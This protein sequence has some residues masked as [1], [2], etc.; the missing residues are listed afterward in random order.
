MG[1]GESDSLARFDGRYAEA[2]LLAPDPVRNVTPSEYETLRG[3]LRVLRRRWIVLITTAC[4]IS[5][6]GSAYYFRIVPSYSA[7][8]IIEINNDHNDMASPTLQD[9]AENSDELTNEIQTD[10][11]ILESDG[12]ALAVIK[13]LGLQNTIY[14]GAVF[15][16]EEN[17]AL[18]QAPITRD[19]MVKSF[20]GNLKVESP[21]STRLISITFDNPNKTRAS[22]VANALAEQ[23]IEDTLER[24]HRS[25]SQSSFWLQKELASLKRQVEQSE[26]NLAD[27]ERKTGLAGVEL[28]GGASDVSVAPHNTVTEKLF[29]LNQELTAAEA[30]RISSETVYNLVHSHDPEVVL[31]LGAGSGGLT[32]DAGIELVRSL[33]GQEASLERE[34]ASAAVKYGANNTR[35]VQLDEQIDT[36]KQEMQDELKR[37][38]ARAENAYKYAK[39]NESSIRKDFIRQQSAANL[40][41]DATVQLHVLAQE[42]YSNRSLYENLFSKL[43]TASL[44]SG[45]GANRIDVVERA[46]PPG[47]PSSPNPRLL[48]AVFSFAIFFGICTAFL[49]EAFDQTVRT[50]QDLDYTHDLPILGYVPK[51]HGSALLQ[52]G[53]GHSELIYSPLSPFSEAFRSVRTS[54]LVAIRSKPARTFLVT[55]ALGDAGKTVVAYNLGV[56]FAQQGARVLLIDADFRHAGLHRLFGVPFSPGLSDVSVETLDKRVPFVVQHDVLPTLFLLPAGKAPHLPAE[57]FGSPLFDGLLRASAARYDF[58]ILDGPPILPVADASIIAAKVEGVVGVLRSRNTTRPIYTAFVK[59]LHRTSSPILGFVLNDV[60]NP[61]LDGFHEYSYTR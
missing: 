38:D 46:V 7:T 28:V 32:S 56:A 11:K 14:K 24:R 37:I 25:T 26:Q 22:E 52:L 44:A 27:Y 35:L 50:S 31:G 48:T 8:T 5:G 3:V 29:A 21:V 20:Q 59:A 39:D 19:R 57:Y 10:I 58:V 45:V 54:L 1:Q 36:I 15:P 43:Q 4:L 60:R 55:S 17:M 49:S 23:F 51:L 40:M 16:G 41:T 61:T 30:S 12:L 42:A 13:R 2:Q 53:T 47:L 18:D 6:I 33:R 34:R 9:T